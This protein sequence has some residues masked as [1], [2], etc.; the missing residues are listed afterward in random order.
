LPGESK[1]TLRE[2]E[3]L[4]DLVKPYDVDF[5]ILQVMP[6]SDIYKNP[7]NYDIIIENKDDCIWYKGIPGKYFCNIKTSNLDSNELIEARDRLEAKFKR[8]ELLR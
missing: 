6:G 5:S 3:T 7:E 8:K 1:D 2:T 4:L